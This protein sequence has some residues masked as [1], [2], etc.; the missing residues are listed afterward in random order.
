[1]NIERPGHVR[2]AY[3]SKGDD[4][5]LSRWVKTETYRRRRTRAFQPLLIETERTARGVTSVGYGASAVR[6]KRTVFQKQVAHP[7]TVT[8]V[9]VSGHSNVKIGRD[10]RKGKF[11]HYWIYTLSLQER[12]TCPESCQH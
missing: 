10:V 3:A 7:S 1:M 5:T 12:A 4:A 2:K 11:K 6:E 9:L 8:N